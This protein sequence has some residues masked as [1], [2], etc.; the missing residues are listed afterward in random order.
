MGGD[1]RECTR[2]P[3]TLWCLGPCLRE[4][5]SGG[6][7][8]LGGGGAGPLGPL[9]VLLSVLRA[10]VGREVW[11][12]PT[13]NACRPRVGKTPG[14]LQG[15]RHRSCFSASSWCSDLRV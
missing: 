14:A 2:A 9:S 13:A 12:E 1:W 11:E 7:L 10:R 6:V 4:A 15:S 8:V 5:E 3:P